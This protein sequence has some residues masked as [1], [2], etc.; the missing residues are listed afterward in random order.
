MLVR[1]LAEALLE[2]TNAFT[3]AFADAGKATWPEQEQDE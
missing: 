2:G 3:E 1:V